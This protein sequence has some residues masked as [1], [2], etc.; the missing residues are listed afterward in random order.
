MKGIRFVGCLIALLLFV[1]SVESCMGQEVTNFVHVPQASADGSAGEEATDGG[2]VVNLEVDGGFLT[3]TIPADYQYQPVEL[4]EIE[5]YPFTYIFTNEKTGVS[6]KAYSSLHSLKDQEHL[7]KKLYDRSNTF[8]VVS[9]GV[10]IG[11][12]TYLVY[13][14]EQATYDYGFLVRTEDGYSYQ[15]HYTLPYDSIQNEIPAEATSILSTLEI[16]ED[17]ELSD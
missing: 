1:L 12:H 8:I 5:R 11:E 2:C 16:H 17:S 4:T 6:F 9:D 10:L 14:K 3:L 15:F 7:L 13:T